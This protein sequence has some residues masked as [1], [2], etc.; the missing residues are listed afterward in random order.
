MIEVLSGFPGDV[1]AF[2]C[3]GRVTRQDYETVLIPTVEQT[4]AK[5]R[6]IR[7][8]YETAA[9][10][11]GIAPGAAWEDLKLGVEHLSRW[12]RMALVTDVEW[13]RH[14]MQAFGFVMPGTIRVFPSAEAAEARA[15]VVAG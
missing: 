15:W 7:I 4:L 5:H 11:A 12:E 1:A 13:I 2:A 14:T 3:H 8:Y 10:F 6:K 9:D